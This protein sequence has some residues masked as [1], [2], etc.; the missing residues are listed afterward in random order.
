MKRRLLL[1]L[2]AVAGLLVSLPAMRAAGG[3]PIEL[4]DDQPTAADA[5][6]TDEP[7]APTPKQTDQA[8]DGGGP[9]EQDAGDTSEP[10][11]PIIERNRL[12]ASSSQPIPGRSHRTF[13]L[14]FERRGSVMLVPGQVEGVEVY[15]IFDT[16]ATYTTL[17]PAIAEQVGALPAKDAPAMKARTANGTRRSRV[18]LVDRLTLGGHLHLGVSFTLCSSCGGQR[19]RG[20]PIAGVL[21][22][23]ILRRYRVNIDSEQGHIQMA[24]NGNYDDR[25]A[26]I[27]PWFDI[28]EV[29]VTF[30][31]TDQL[32]STLRFTTEN[33]SPRRIDEAR[34]RITCPAPSSLDRQVTI[35][36]AGRTE[37]QHDLT[38]SS[39][40]CRRPRVRLISASW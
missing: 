40:I 25:S 33:K 9:D 6:T 15:F 35:S 14:E 18:G 34:L 16:G 24:P 22:L 20:A 4:F 30:D 17:T 12:S 10:K 37:K 31:Q 27:K 21:G 2:A 29:D 23:N 5:G 8:P 28:R 36:L 26:D 13:T 39:D 3:E 7:A 38:T 32:H 1:P 19:Y 11:G